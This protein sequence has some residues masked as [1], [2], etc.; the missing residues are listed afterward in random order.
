MAPYEK[1]R[2]RILKRL[3]I[4]ITLFI[5]TFFLFIFIQ[6][7]FGNYFSF[8]EVSP[9]TW[10]LLTT[11]LIALSY[12]PIDHLYTWLFKHV[13]FPRRSRT[14]SILS[15]LSHD[16]A[17]AQDL[18]VLANLL[19]NTLGETLQLKTVSLLIHNPRGDH[20]S[21]AS[22]YGWSVT[23]YRKI[24]LSGQS[25]LLQFMKAMGSQVLLRSKVIRSLSWQEANELTKDFEALHATCVIPLW[26][27]TELLGSLN[28]LSATPEEQPD[29]GDLRFLKDFGQEIANS[30]GHALEIQ[31]LRM[32]NEELRDAQSKLHQTAKL[33]AIEQ[34][35]TGIAHEIHN[36]LT[37]ISGK[38]Q[39]LLLQKDHKLF[40][41]KVEEVLK[42]IVKQTRR[43]A[44]ITK[45]LLMFSQTS[46]TL[47]ER[48]RLE[49]ILE[50]TLSLIAYRVSLEEIEIQRLIANDLPDFYGNVQE[51]R[52]VFFNLVFNAVQAVDAGGR[53]QI[54][55]TFQRADK[56]FVIQIADSG[57]GILPEHLDKVFNPFFSTRPEGTG[58]GLFVAQQIVNRYG[59]SIRV[60]SQA[61][62]GTI[63]VV[64]LPGNGSVEG[65]NS[66]EKINGSL[67]DSKSLEV[68]RE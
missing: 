33:S 14:L 19:V 20:Y 48:I 51:L 37:I 12:Q 58:L 63:F 46:A 64:E 44:D 62:E 53:I 45:K 67:I 31:E 6:Y 35:A 8:T 27:K 39:V 47:H 65:K 42:T 66:V 52:E 40:D 34:L 43:A 41:E 1:R 16:V 36:P 68:T 25:P 10:I 11:F 23:G 4:G 5:L 7:F 61:A 2:K 59:G 22:A 57:P 26:S 3:F 29:D 50:D 49:T 60:E 9:L 21:V 32:A 54:G 55:I 18:R 30:L 28:L 24:Q 13:L 17:H 38:A 56:I 15:R